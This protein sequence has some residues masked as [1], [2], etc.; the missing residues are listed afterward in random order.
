MDDLILFYWRPVL[1]LGAT[2]FHICL[3]LFDV[4]L[5]VLMESLVCCIPLVDLWVAKPEF[6]DIDL[7]DRLAR[8][9]FDMLPF[10]VPWVC[11]LKSGY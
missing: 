2:F 6:F 7:Y 4:L 5:T 1:I 3:A 11:Y 8:F 10:L 9:K